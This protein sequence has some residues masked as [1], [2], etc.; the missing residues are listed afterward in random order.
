M[1]APKESG[2]TQKESAHGSS[3]ASQAKPDRPDDTRP[4]VTL[5]GWGAL[6]LKARRFQRPRRRK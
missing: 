1:A 6:A 2:R 4:A 5:E 3:P